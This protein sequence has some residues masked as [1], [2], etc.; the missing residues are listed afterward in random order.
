MSRHRDRGELQQR[1][2]GDAPPVAA[3]NQPIAGLSDPGARCVDDQ[4]PSRSLLAVVALLAAPDRVG[5]AHRF[6]GSL[7]ID[8]RPGG[9]CRLVP[10][11]WR[12]R[13]GPHRLADEILDPAS[14]RGFGSV[15]HRAHVVQRPLCRTSASDGAGGDRPSNQ[16]CQRLAHCVVEGRQIGRLQDGAVVAPEA[17]DHFPDPLD[18]GAGPALVRPGAG[19]TRAHTVQLPRVDR[20]ASIREDDAEK[21][22]AVRHGRYRRRILVQPEAEIVEARARVRNGPLGRRGARRR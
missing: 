4:L 6:S 17:G 20:A 19:Q 5:D 21:D 12:R 9:F 7:R 22:E 18:G 10:S 2:I 8:L 11:R 14:P 16:A 15:S 1:N 13:G 3:H